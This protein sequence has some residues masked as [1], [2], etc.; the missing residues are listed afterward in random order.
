MYRQSS[1]RKNRNVIFDLHGVLLDKE[2]SVK[3]IRAV[4]KLRKD[5]YRL[6]FV[7]N[8][9]T[10][11]SDCIVKKLRALG[12]VAFSH[13]A[14]TAGMA[15]A[16]YLKRYYQ[17]RSVLAIG[18]SQFKSLL[19][20]SAAEYTVV[21]DRPAEVVVVGGTSEL[22]DLALY[23]AYQSANQG[24]PLIATSRDRYMFDGGSADNNTEST[25]MR[26]EQ[27]MT[28]KAYVLGKPNIYML[29]EMLLLSKPELSDSVIVGDSLESDVLLGNHAGAYTILF[30][31][32][33]I[34]TGNGGCVP[35]IRIDTL[36][37]ITDLVEA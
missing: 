31:S 30:R 29:T 21:Y 28:T 32:E 35:D 14:V 6:F 8:S 2:L 26:I 4:N 24:A 18:K 37:N 34:A 9:S 15:V 20:R 16:H 33:A 5:G 7:T 36:D 22:F 1:A 12:I 17:N 10:L 13:E 23:A 19:A 3:S 11:T 27:I 25:V